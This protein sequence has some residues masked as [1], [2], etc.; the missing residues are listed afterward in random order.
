MGKASASAVSNYVDAY[1]RGK[2]DDKKICQSNLGVLKG[3]ASDPSVT[4]NK[5]KDQ[6]QAVNAAEA[7]GLTAPS[8]GAAK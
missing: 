8:S 2:T 5:I 1:T 4:L 7:K 3:L 6:I